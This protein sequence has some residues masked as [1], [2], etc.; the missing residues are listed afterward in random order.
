MSAPSTPVKAPE[1]ELQQ[2]RDLIK[3][4][5]FLFVSKTWCPDCVYGKKVFSDLNT[6][7]P[8]LVELDLLDNGKELQSAFLEITKQNTVP[9]VFIDG[10]H[11]GTEDDIARLLESGELKQKLETAGLIP[12]N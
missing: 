10:E 5:K 9:N 4:E 2:A 11:I 7:P 1:A 3:N 6:S 8:H 12:Q